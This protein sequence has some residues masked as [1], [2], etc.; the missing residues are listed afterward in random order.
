MFRRLGTFSRFWQ[1]AALVL[2]AVV[3]GSLTVLLKSCGSGGSGN[4]AG[5]E[6]PT[7][8]PAAGSAAAILGL[9]VDPFAQLCGPGSTAALCTGGPVFSAGNSVQLV[10]LGSRG[11]ILSPPLATATL[12]SNLRFTIPFSGS[13]T[14]PPGKLVSVQSNFIGQ[15]RQAG[16]STPLRGFVFSAAVDVSPWSE[17]L[18]RILLRE[19]E[20]VPFSNL[21]PPEVRDLENILF[22]SIPLSRTARN[23][24]EVIADIIQQADRLSFNGLRFVE[25]LIRVCYAPEGNQSDQPCRL[26]IPVPTPPPVPIEPPATRPPASPLAPGTP[27]P[28]ATPSP[29]APALPIVITN[30]ASVRLSSGTLVFSNPVTVRVDNL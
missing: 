2:A 1:P 22:V 3:T 18:Y 26:R 17:A 16:Q 14:Q 21:A 30:R 5:V 10:G 29:E 13:I 28:A 27:L 11:D 23:L 12:D 7:R 25:D 9:V 19:R 8:D 15:G 4:P 24:E 20:R 6:L